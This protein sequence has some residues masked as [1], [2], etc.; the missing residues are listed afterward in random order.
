MGFLPPFKEAANVKAAK[1]LL[2][3]L[4]FTDHR[5]KEASFLAALQNRGSILM[6]GIVIFVDLSPNPYGW[7]A[8]L[9]E[10]PFGKVCLVDFARILSDGSY[11]FQG[12][13]RVRN[14]VET[15]DVPRDRTHT[16]L[17]IGADADKFLNRTIEPGDL[18]GF[19][20]ASVPLSAGGNGGDGGD[21]DDDDDN[22]DPNKAMEGGYSVEIKTTIVPKGAWRRGVSMSEKGFYVD[23]IRDMDYDIVWDC[24]TER[25]TREDLEKVLGVGAN[26][27]LFEKGKKPMKKKED[28]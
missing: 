10:N 25:N 15:V 8:G 2:M 21:D 9:I 17:L 26:V 22:R 13:V 19:R 11:N 23:D 20:F 3:T 5:P 18:V 27:T 12:K 1:E 28:S 14:G 16:A 4:V 6:F 24:R 7:W